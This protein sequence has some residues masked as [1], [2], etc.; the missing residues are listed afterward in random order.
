MIG[1]LVGPEQ[2]FFVSSTPRHY[3]GC[4]AAIEEGDENE[5]AKKAQLARDARHR[6]GAA[7]LPTCHPRFGRARCVPHVSIDNLFYQ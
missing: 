2:F 5:D 6:L 1:Y 7:R 4:N 3:V